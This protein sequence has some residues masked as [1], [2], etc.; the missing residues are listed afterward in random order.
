MYS[1]I[2]F[3]TREKGDARKKES[4]ARGS[5]SSRVAIFINL[6]RSLVGSRNW[7]GPR[8]QSVFIAGRGG[9]G[10]GGK[11]RWN[12][13]DTP[14]ECYFTEVIPP[15]NFWWLSRS[16]TVF[17]FQANLSGPHSES[18]RSFQR[19]PLLCSQLQLIPLLFYQK[20]SDPPKI[21]RP[22]PQAINNDQCLTHIWRTKQVLNPGQIDGSRVLWPLPHPSLL[23]SVQNKVCIL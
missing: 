11:T 7:P 12:L 14:F 3:T 5:P 1:V 8:D 4:T 16:P 23:C 22:R 6:A 21:L 2:F 17:I 20:S 10:F 15:N 19:S 13:A 18:I 9:G